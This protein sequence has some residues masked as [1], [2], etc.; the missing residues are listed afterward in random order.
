L[1]SPSPF[2]SEV[3]P[4]KQAAVVLAALPV[5]ILLFTIPSWLG[6]YD[7]DQHFPWTVAS[8]FTLLFGIG[9]SVL[10]LGADDQNKYWS[11]SI[12]CYAFVMIIGGLMA[13]LFSGQSVF[14]AKSFSKLYIVFTFGYLLFL[15]IGRAMRK[16]VKIA[17]KQ[18][19]ALRGEDPKD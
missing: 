2:K 12:P 14:E 8:A 1:E 3:S 19:A 16:I 4:F 6:I 7:V 11:K 13:W 5:T 15:C 10:G 17:I 18:D 9:N